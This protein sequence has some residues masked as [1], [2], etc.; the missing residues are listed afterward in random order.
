MKNRTWQEFVRFCI[1]G[2][3]TFLI[4]CSLLIY[5]TEILNIDYLVSSAIS[6][7]VAVTINYILCLVFVF[8]KYRNG[9]KQFILFLLSSIGGLILNQLFM[10][11]FVEICYFHYLLAK[12]LAT[13]GVTLWN[14]IT[15]KKSLAIRP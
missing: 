3:I 13:I 5:L 8:A 9:Y 4:D 10:W 12:I 2:G 14:Y 7:S 11:L 1:V 15:K 6:F